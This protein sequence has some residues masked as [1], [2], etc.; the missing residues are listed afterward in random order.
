MARRP[1]TA[2][3]NGHSTQ[4]VPGVYESTLRK[5]CEQRVEDATN[6]LVASDDPEQ[7]AKWEAEHASRLAA[8]MDER[9]G[10]PLRVRSSQLPS[11]L[12]PP[13]ENYPRG[14]QRV[15]TITDDDVITLTMMGVTR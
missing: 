15:F 1:P 12:P 7:M 10:Q 5:L 14:G 2:T 4:H 9:R 3:A 13:F 11:N 8:L 6:W